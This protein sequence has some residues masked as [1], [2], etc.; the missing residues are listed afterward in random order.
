MS[1]ETKAPGAPGPGRGQSRGRSAAVWIVLV[2]A[3][4]LLLVSSFAIWVNRVALN[5]SVF[6]DTSTSLLDDD[7][8]RAAVANRAVDELFDNVDVQA[9]VE[10]QLPSGYKSLSGPATAGLR[11][12][13][14]QI[15][16]R[17]LQQPA[18]QRLFRVTL[19]QTH[20]TLVQVLEGGGDRVSTANGEVTLDLRPIIQETADRIG[21]GDKIAGKIPA[22]TGRIVILRADELNTAQNVFELLK[23]LAWVLPILTLL[24]FGLAVWLSGDR[25]SVVRNVGIVLLSVGVLGLLAASFTRNYVIDALVAQQDDREAASNAWNILSELMRGS[26]RLMVVIGILFLVAAWL[27]GPSRLALGVRSWLAVALRR[28][29]WAYIGLAVV[30]L[31]MLSRSAV[32]DFTRLLTVA[33]VIALGI[34]WIELTR[35]RTLE[36]FPDGASPTLVTDARERMSDWW[37]SRRS[38]S[39]AVPATAA[40]AVA[41]TD[42]AGRL[43]SLADLHARGEL[44][45]EEYAS[46]KAQV[47]AGS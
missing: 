3:G 30:A 15:A 42:V 45:D 33:I 43:A 17:A 28:R 18:F 35:A 24:V 38:E 39:T 36:E 8:I 27:A 25:R 5:T 21:I 37:E 4:L 31:F 11:Q 14:Y 46:A 6:T 40:A 12:A 20:K 44:T 22:D 23:T 2:I 13:S 1:A 9:E 34:V 10:A 7:K 26:F 16:D 19:E 32:A 47:L 29:I 41:P